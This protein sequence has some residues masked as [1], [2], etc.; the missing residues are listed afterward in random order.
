MENV[1]TP[2][3]DK[4]GCL[5]D[6]SLDGVAVA[7]VDTDVEDAVVV[8]CL[9]GDSDG[10]KTARDLTATMT[11]SSV[12]NLEEGT[13]SSSSALN[14]SLRALSSLANMEPKS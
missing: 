6:P 3:A 12:R 11:S 10:M 1:P 2:R 7:E 4:S 9:L 14:L 13:A 5:L 8:G